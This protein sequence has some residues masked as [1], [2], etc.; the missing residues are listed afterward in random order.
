MHVRKSG[1][2]FSACT[3]DQIYQPFIP[4]TKKWMF[5]IFLPSLIFCLIAATALYF[6]INMTYG[7]KTIGKN[8][9]QF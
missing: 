9:P 4:L 3:G 1:V 5:I 7:S 8:S 6:I 2:F